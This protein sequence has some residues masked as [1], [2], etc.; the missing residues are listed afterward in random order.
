MQSASWWQTG[1]I[2][3]IYPRSFQDSNGDGVGDLRGIIEWLPYLSELGIDAI[4]ISPIFVSPMADFGYDIA[5]YTGI[6]PLFGTLED[7]DALLAAAHAS[8]LKVILDLVPNH[9]SDQHPWLSKAAARDRARNEIGISGAIPLPTADLPTTGC[10]NSAAVRGSTMQR[11]DN[12]IT[13]RFS[14]HSLT[15]TGAIRKCAPPCSMSCASGCGAV[16][17][18]SVSMSSGT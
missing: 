6:D 7:F 5:D 9:T 14:P 3:Q 11:T 16:S 1:V 12:T 15:S 2:Y 13:T 4:W 18:D 10:R 17:M 8:G